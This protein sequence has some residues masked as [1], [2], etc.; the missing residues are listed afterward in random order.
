MRILTFLLLPIMLA[1]GGGGGGLLGVT[2]P[3]ATLDRVD[4][5]DAPTADQALAW[6]CFE[7]L[8]EV[9]CQAAGWD[10][11]PS[12]EK[13]TFSFDVVF[14]LAN[15]NADIDIPLVEVLLAVTVYDDQN[16]GAVCVSFCD[17]DQEDCEPGVD[18][19]G[20]CTVDDDTTEVKDVEDLVPSVDDLVALE[21]GVADGEFDNGEGIF[22]AQVLRQ[23]PL[24]ESETGS[25]H[26][27]FH[28]ERRQ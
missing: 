13:M 10:H 12:D 26:P 25:V 22:Y 15:N 19:E 16:L 18:E 3:V 28:D 20:A 5:L 14:Q 7:Y 23:R 8:G 2:A 4:L 24:T 9:T 21:E 11:Q 1:C 6:S 17:P 27:E